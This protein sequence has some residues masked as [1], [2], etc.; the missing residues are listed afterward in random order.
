MFCF[1]FFFCSFFILILCLFVFLHVCMS[2]CLSFYFR[3]FISFI[4]LFLF[5][6]LPFFLS[7]FVIFS[8]IF[9][10]PSLFTLPRTFSCLTDET[11]AC[12]KISKI[13]V[14]N[15]S[16]TKEQ[17]PLRAPPALPAKQSFMPAHVIIVLNLFCFFVFFALAK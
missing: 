17:A 16:Q 2:S 9:S 8:L 1:H 6:F 12:V 4:F 14:K 10:P 5:C 11:L 3:L 15:K 7:F 13:F